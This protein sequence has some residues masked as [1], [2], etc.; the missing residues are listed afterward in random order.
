[1]AD[2]KKPTENERAAEPRYY[3]WH[4]YAGPI[5]F[6]WD[7]WEVTEEEYR[8]YASAEAITD[9]DEVLRTTGAE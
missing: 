2:T 8:H 6:Y 7:D 5:Q 4:T 3:W 9:L 1:M